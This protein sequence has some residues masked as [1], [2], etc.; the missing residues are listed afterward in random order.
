[1]CIRDSS[2]STD[3]GSRDSG[4]TNSGSSDSSSSDS[5]SDSDSS[6][7]DSEQ[8]HKQKKNSIKE[9]LETKLEAMKGGFAEMKK[10]DRG[11]DRKYGSRN[12]VDKIKQRANQQDKSKIQRQSV[13]NG[14][15][16]FGGKTILQQAQQRQLHH[17]SLI[18]I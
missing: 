15:R 3:S 5:D 7:S 4:S 10:Y 6:N 8:L 13:I 17:L 11:Y 18:H 9:R 2:S 1:M 14:R 12:K 16:K